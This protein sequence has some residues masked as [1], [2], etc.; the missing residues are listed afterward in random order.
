MTGC[1]RLGTVG[2]MALSLAACSVVNA[3]IDWYRDATGVS[4]NDDVGKNDNQKNLEA[5]TK[6]PRPNLA[7]V[8]QPPDRAMSTA[9]REALRQSLVADRQNAHYT[10]DQLQA[11]SPVPGMVAPPAPAAAPPVIASPKPAP[12][13]PAPQREPAPAESSLKSPE[14][15]N[16]PQGETPTPPPPAPTV[17]PSPPIAET[18][19]P[20]AATPAP[21]SAPLA[22]SPSRGSPAKAAPPPV[23]SAAAAP[24]PP[25]KIAATEPPPRP[26]GPPAGS[27]AAR[28]VEIADVTFTPDSSQVSSAL[29]GTLVEVVAQHKARQGRVRIVGYAQKTRGASTPQDLASYN[30]ALDRAKSVAASLTE[31]GVAAGD[32]SVEA[33]VE[34]AGDP[35]AEIYMNK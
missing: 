28:Q 20:R 32:I 14:I 30:L 29:H 21:S 11:G 35:R 27:N 2:L 34:A 6:E 23:S 19:V 22:S 5:G 12:A 15:A 1:R 8:P 33:S 31:L 10:E 7:E 24:P 4:K 18:P 16:I 13:K 26:T 17:Q 3:P 25:P 9:E